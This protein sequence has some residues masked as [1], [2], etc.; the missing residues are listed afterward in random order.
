ML[1]SISLHGHAACAS[2]C[3]WVHACNARVSVYLVMNV[4]ALCFTWGY[5]SLIIH[6][7]L[8]C[9]KPVNSMDR[10][11]ATEFISASLTL[12]FHLCLSPSFIFLLSL[13]LRLLSALLAVCLVCLCLPLCPANLLTS[14]L[15]LNHLHSQP[16]RNRHGK[17]AETD[18]VVD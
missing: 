8:I 7:A 2:M 13:Y 18:S 1:V 10:K 14:F 16:E 17:D 5:K 15:S 6:H 9:Y 12:S 11:N 4:C 3:A